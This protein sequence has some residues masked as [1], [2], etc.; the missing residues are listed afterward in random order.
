M[1]SEETAE[2]IAVTQRGPLLNIAFGGASATLTHIVES[3]HESNNDTF[4]CR[5]GTAA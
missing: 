2:E 4:V 3:D 1:T 5:R